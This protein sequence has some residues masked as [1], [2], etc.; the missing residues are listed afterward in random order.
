MFVTIVLTCLVLCLLY[1]VI[2]IRPKNFPPG[3]PCL[4]VV[5]C[6]PFLPSQYLH[7]KMELWLKKYGSV[8]GLMLGSQPA[9]LICGP[10]EV[11]EVLRREEFQGRP[12]KANFRQENFNRKLGVFFSDGPFWVEQR[13]FTLRHLRDLGFGKSIMETLISEEIEDVI[14]ELRQ[15]KV[16]QVSRF[17]GLS[18]VNVIWA[19]VAGTRYSRGDARLQD[20]LHALTRLFR[21]GS[22]TGGIVNAVPILKIIAPQV[23]G[24][25]ET[26]DHVT[27]LKF[28]FR[29]IIRE[30]DKTFK[31]NDLRD[32]IDVY[33]KE[34]KH[35]SDNENSTFS[36]D[37][38]IITCFDLFAAGAESV[39]NTLS[40]TLL[41][42]V[43]HP[44]VQGTVQRL[45]DDV[46][47]KDRRPCLADRP[48]LQYV[49]AVLAE[50][51]RIN[52]VAAVAPAHRVTQDTTLNGYSI[53][54]D[55]TVIASLWCILRDKEHWGDPEVFRPERFLDENDNFVKDEWMIPFGIG[56]RTCLGELMARNILFIFYTT[57]LQ[58]FS[59]SL[60]VGD[61]E[62]S[63]LCL[64]GI[65]SAPQPFRVKITRRS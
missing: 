49:E 18:T 6:V 34:M 19:L 25:Q 47:G 10:N 16:L 38:L 37:G 56:R 35:Q 7:L 45:L 15:C 27:N 24:H 55:T 3:P 29:N 13:R 26:L 28:F 14:K 2:K 11:L 54:K 65:T 59:F 52:T 1:N 44:E 63:T 5:G 17:F 12:E 31:E 23:T 32:F 58:E 8:V 42:T 4:P 41:Y 30:H 50:V 21:S 51:M 53:P 48:R 36:E 57:L 43:L 46:V 61:P 20:L 60:P 22:Q 9:V 64:S 39:S 62:P 33:L 40:F